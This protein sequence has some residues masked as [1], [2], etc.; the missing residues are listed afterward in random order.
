MAGIGLIA[1]AFAAGSERPA[2]A[3]GATGTGDTVNGVPV[4]GTNLT[5]RT[6][7]GLWQKL[8]DITIDAN[9]RTGA[10]ENGKIIAGL[11]ERIV[12]QRVAIYSNIEY[13]PSDNPPSATLFVLDS[14]YHRQAW[15][16]LNVNRQD[17]E[18]VSHYYIVNT[19]VLAVV[20]PG[21]SVD[22][23]FA[24]QSTTTLPINA[25]VTLSGYTEY[26]S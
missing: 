11:H 23:T 24:L 5:P 1:L 19:E 6:T 8:D 21:S 7:V 15:I 18:V 20:E 10:L 9:Q 14:L 2:G 12:I 4:M 17:Y 16:P 22:V 3:A 25:I 13:S 26:V